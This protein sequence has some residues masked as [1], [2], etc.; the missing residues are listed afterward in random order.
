VRWRA[1]KGKAVRTGEFP[2]G[3]QAEPSADDALVTTLKAAY[4]ETRR[5]SERLRDA[6]ASVTRQLGPLPI[7]AGVVAGLVTGFAPSGQRVTDHVWILYVAGGLFALLVVLSIAYSNLKPYRQLRDEKLNA[8]CPKNVDGLES[9]SGMIDRLT[10][11]PQRM[12]TQQASADWYRAMI[13]LEQEIYGQPRAKWSQNRFPGRIVSLQ[14][15]FERE[16][17]GLILVQGLFA[18]VVVLLILARVIE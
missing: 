8:W 2:S 16:R 6:R 13:R 12:A 15:G 18:V 4:E 17:S 10:K 1:S 11:R 7:S 3:H 5:E 9:P 14:E